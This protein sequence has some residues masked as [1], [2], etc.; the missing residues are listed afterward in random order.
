MKVLVFLLSI[1]F[2]IFLLSVMLFVW[3]IKNDQFE[4]PEKGAS[5]IF[6]EDDEK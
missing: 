3:F 6:V 1:A 2:F 4:D 5:Q